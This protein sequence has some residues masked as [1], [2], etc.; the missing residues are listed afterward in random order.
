LGFTTL[1]LFF[2]HLREQAGLSSEDVARTLTS[3]TPVQLEVFETDAGKIPLA[4]IFQMANFF[5]ADPDAVLALVDKGVIGEAG[6]QTVLKI[7]G[8]GSAFDPQELQS[9]YYV[10]GFGKISIKK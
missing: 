8:S 2:K 4:N 7:F 1:G 10:N 6:D 3:V 5:N 9:E